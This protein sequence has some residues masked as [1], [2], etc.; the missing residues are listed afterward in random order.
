[1]IA[2]IDGEM[3]PDRDFGL[4]TFG[5]NPKRSIKDR[6]VLPSSEA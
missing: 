5:I 2:R 4:M 6:H 1:M 3:N